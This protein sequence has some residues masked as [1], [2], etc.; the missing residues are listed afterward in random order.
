MRLTAAV[1][2]SA[3]DPLLQVVKT[4][5]ATIV[6]WVVCDLLIP[7]GPPPVFGAIAAMLVVQPSLNQS[8]AKGVERSVGVVAGV[9]LATGMGVVLGTSAWVVLLAVTAA[10]GLSWALRLT[11]GSGIQIAISALLVLTLGASTPDYAFIRIVE[12]MIGAVI[13]IVIHLLLVPPVALAPA[14]TA[15][16]LLGVETAEAME[17]LADALVSKKTRPGRILLIVDARRLSPLRDE[18]LETIEAAADSLTLN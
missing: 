14:R 4:V 13:G 17:R 8:L 2:A 7:D 16:D 11:T 6:A 12:T 15:L 1:R 18:A 3:R 9:L 10:F 5:L